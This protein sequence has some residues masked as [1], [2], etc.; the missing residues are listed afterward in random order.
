[1]VSGESRNG[2]LTYKLRP[3]EGPIFGHLAD[4]IEPSRYVRFA[5]STD[6]SE[7]FAKIFVVVRVLLDSCHDLMFQLFFG[8]IL[9]PAVLDHTHL[10]RPS[11]HHLEHPGLPAGQCVGTHVVEHLSISIFF[12]P[13][14]K[15]KVEI[16]LAGALDGGIEAKVYL[17]GGGKDGEKLEKRVRVL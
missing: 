7:V 9:D 4:I 5:I 11:V 3:F 10:L 13:G 1:M 16:G 15:Q 2:E 17:E 12:L 6:V 8:I 14:G